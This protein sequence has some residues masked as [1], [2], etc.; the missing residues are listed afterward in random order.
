MRFGVFNK[1]QLPNPREA[2]ERRLFGDL[3]VDAW[4]F[5]YDGGRAGDL[6]PLRRRIDV[7]VLTWGLAGAR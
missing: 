7:A 4:F 5:E 3:P 6:P 2:A 1:V